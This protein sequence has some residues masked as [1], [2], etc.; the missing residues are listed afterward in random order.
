MVSIGGNE[1]EEM[2]WVD[3]AG[4]MACMTVLFEAQTVMFLRVSEALKIVNW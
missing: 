3:H 1:V 2:G 4:L